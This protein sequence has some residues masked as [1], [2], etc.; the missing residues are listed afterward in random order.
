MQI[1]KLPRFYG[2]NHQIT[3]FF[4][5]NHTI[6]TL[7]WNHQQFLVEITKSPVNFDLNH[8]S[9]K[10][11]PLSTDACPDI[12]EIINIVF[13]HI[14]HVVLLALLPYC[15]FGMLSMLYFKI[16]M[17]SKLRTLNKMCLD[18]TIT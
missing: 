10:I 12:A 2:L 1:T 14:Q 17:L 15:S 8:Q 3:T 7:S 4:W 5:V 16:A 13:W 6:T 11:L 9:P 18:C